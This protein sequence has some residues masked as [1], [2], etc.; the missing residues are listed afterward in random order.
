MPGI[1]INNL[2]GKSP[3]VPMTGNGAPVQVTGNQTADAQ[4]RA[5]LG[6]ITA[7]GGRAG[8]T[9]IRA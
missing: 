5:L 9:S 3:Y 2:S 4:K 6:T 7:A 1:S 8:Q